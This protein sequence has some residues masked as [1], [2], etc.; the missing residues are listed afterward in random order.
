MMNHN[1]AFELLAP[2]SLHALDADVMV[3][4][5]AHVANCPRCRAE[6][7]GLREVAAA[8]GNTVEPLPDG[9]WP[10]IAS[11]LSER[12]NV[13]HRDAP[14]LLR[15][16]VD[17]FPI[18]IHAAKLIVSRRA[19]AMYGGILA[20]A[21]ASILALGF[22]FANANNHVLQLQGAL[23]VAN[24]GRAQLALSAPGHRIITLRTP[25][26][27][28]IAEF[29]M[30]PDG[31]GYLVSSALPSLRSTMTYQLWGIVK[32][33][34]VSIGVMGGTPGQVTFT[35][36]GSPTYPRPLRSMQNNRHCWRRSIRDSPPSRWIDVAR[37]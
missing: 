16:E 31:R 7:D 14:Q 12:P 26:H 3:Q 27:L 15:S 20:A 25:Q 35:M 29:V 37:T 33:S 32:G 36:A 24:S 13:V 1:E 34:P 19:K 28:P 2:L 23:N 5:D 18:P 9:L 21:A 8:M 6:I 30:L 4:M 22:G 17:G 11:R 10:R